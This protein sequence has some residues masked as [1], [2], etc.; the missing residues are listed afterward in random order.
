MYLRNLLKC[1]PENEHVQTLQKSPLCSC[2]LYNIKYKLVSA[3]DISSTES[4]RHLLEHKNINCCDPQK[5][6]T[7]ISSYYIV[8]K[9]QE[10]E[11]N[12]VEK[13]R[14]ILLSHPSN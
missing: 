10:N 14:N 8:D 13:C 7:F 11:E 1:Q 12:I 3:R 2:L 9:W 4:N 5:G 6:F